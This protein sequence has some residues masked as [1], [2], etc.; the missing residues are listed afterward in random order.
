MRRVPTPSAHDRTVTAKNTANG[1]PH[2]VAGKPQRKKPH[3]A[4]TAATMPAVR[5]QSSFLRG[6]IRPSSTAHFF[7]AAAMSVLAELSFLP[8]FTDLFARELAAGE[9]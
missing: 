8:D 2:M 1:R 9:C 7:T 4:R 5:T 6:T 3:T